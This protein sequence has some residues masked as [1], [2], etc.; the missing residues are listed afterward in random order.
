MSISGHALLSG[1]DFTG[2]CSSEPELGVSELRLAFQAAGAT[3]CLDFGQPFGRGIDWCFR[4][5]VK[6][7]WLIRCYCK[8]T[9]KQRYDS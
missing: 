1:Q 8:Q 9:S 2:S 4:L 7:G 3:T 5:L 6:H